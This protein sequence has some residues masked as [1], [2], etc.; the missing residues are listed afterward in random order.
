MSLEYLRNGKV[1][2]GVFDVKLRGAVTVD[3]LR[4]SSLQVAEICVSNQN[5]RVSSMYLN[6]VP[7]GYTSFVKFPKSCS[8]MADNK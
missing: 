5:S 2:T 3:A 4:S 7:L 6:L 1:C 8:K